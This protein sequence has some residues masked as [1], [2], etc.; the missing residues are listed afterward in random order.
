MHFHP[1]S[2][3]DIYSCWAGQEIRLLNYSFS[4]GPRHFVLLFYRCSITVSHCS[5]LSFP[6]L[7]TVFSEEP[8]YSFQAPALLFSLFMSPSFSPS[9]FSADILARCVHGFVSSAKSIPRRSAGVSGQAGATAK[10]ITGYHA[11]NLASILGHPWPRYRICIMHC[12][13]TNQRIWNVEK[14][15]ELL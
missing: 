3:S 11:G 12:L 8:L 13:R 4:Q 5:H 6:W 7:N 15:W 10:W 2:V 14:K 1:L 9:S